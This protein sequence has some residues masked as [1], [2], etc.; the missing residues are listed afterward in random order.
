MAITTEVTA[1]LINCQTKLPW[2]EKVRLL[3]G[4]LTPNWEE[5]SCR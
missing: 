1:L 5:T 2:F 4:L 3:N